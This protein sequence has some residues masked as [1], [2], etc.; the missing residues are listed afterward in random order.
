MDIKEFGIEIHVPEN[1]V[2]PIRNEINKLGACRIGNYDHVMAVTQIVG[3]WRPLENSNPVEGEKGKI[4]RGT[5]CMVTVRCPSD[6]VKQVLN[7]IYEIHPYEEPVINVIPLMN[8]H[9]GIK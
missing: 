6:S 7:K 5:Q 3:Y 8:S 2:E 1:Y 9:F 4:N